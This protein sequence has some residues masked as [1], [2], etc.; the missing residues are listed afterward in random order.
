MKKLA[1]LV[2]ALLA[3]SGTALAADADGVILTKVET[4][5]RTDN[6]T[7]YN[8]TKWV[9][10]GFFKGNNWGDFQLGY[11][12]SKTHTELEDEDGEQEFEFR[13]GYNHKTSWGEFG[14][15][16]IFEQGRVSGSDSNN[17]GKGWDS[18][19]PEVWG[20]YNINDKS[21]V[22]ARALYETKE[23]TGD[24]ALATNGVS[25][26][27]FEVEAQYRYDIGGGTA[28]VGAFYAPSVEDWAADGWEGTEETRLLANYAK[29]W[30]TAKVFTVLYGDVR[31]IKSSEGGDW[32][33]AYKI[34]LYAN[35]PLPFMD[36][37]VLEGEINRFSQFDTIWTT[38]NPYAE[39]FFMLGMRYNY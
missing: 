8:F 33:N 27:W 16:V 20:T 22:F 2:T 38:S 10:D 29:W 39:N 32:C 23:V 1:L 17:L 15:Q 30:P 7:D 36:G 24:T 4:G 14:G 13:P 25:N 9:T 26:D 21:R 28:M 6:G 12:F 3:I 37:L 34:S 18:I 31:E 19:K 35:T 5:N 11:M